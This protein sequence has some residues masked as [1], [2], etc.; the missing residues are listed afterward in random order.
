M[1]KPGLHRRRRF[2][3]TLL[4]LW[5]IIFLIFAV[6]SDLRPWRHTFLRGRYPG[7][8]K[9]MLFR[10]S[11]CA[12][13]GEKV[14]RSDWGILTSR[15]F[16]Q[17]CESEFKG[18][19]LLP[20]FVVVAGILLGLFGFGSYLNSGSASDARV[21]RQPA[22]LV[23]QS[24]GVAQISSPNPAPKVLRPFAE[25]PASNF[26]ERSD[27]NQTPPRTARAPTRAPATEGPTYFCGA[28][29]K[30]GT[31]CSR[32]VKGKTRCYQHTGMPIMDSSGRLSSN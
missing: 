20:R 16:C 13:C 21:V 4:I 8:V 15:R 25:N 10:P 14:E 11:F 28:E 29:T 18:H 22:K 24:A 30:K 3:L 31:A 7:M 26:S 2:V 19:D 27:G 17:V 32:R 5:F 23:E 6:R 9:L 1:T 12:N